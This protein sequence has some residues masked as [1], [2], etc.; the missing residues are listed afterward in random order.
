MSRPS[1]S[2]WG[3]EA[4]GPGFPRRSGHD[5][6]RCLPVGLRRHGFSH[7]SDPEYPV[8]VMVASVSCC[9]V[10]DSRITNLLDGLVRRV[11]RCVLASPIELTLTCLLSWLSQVRF[12]PGAPPSLLRE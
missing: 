10:P 3:G 6:R 11:V 5:A 8:L 9:G 1:G 4:R 12:L 2:W 7:G